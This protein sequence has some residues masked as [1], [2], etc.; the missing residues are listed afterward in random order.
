MPAVSEKQRRFLGAALAAKRGGKPISKKVAKAASSMS[1]QQLSD[2]VSK[3]GADA[4]GPTAMAHPTPQQHAVNVTVNLMQ[5]HKPPRARKPKR[6]FK[7]EPFGTHEK[8]GRDLT[9][10]GL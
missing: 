1:E 8:L 7:H 10:V 6:K 3:D 4:P 5:G 9:K 2:F